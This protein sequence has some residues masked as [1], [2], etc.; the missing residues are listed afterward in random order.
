M[1]MNILTFSDETRPLAHSVGKGYMIFNSDTKT[2]QV[3]DGTYWRDMDG[4]LV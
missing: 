3:S 1:V 4:N 2:I